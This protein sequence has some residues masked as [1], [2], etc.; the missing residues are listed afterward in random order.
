MPGSNDESAWCPKHFVGQA[1]HFV[2]A[3]NMPAYN[4]FYA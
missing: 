4:N 3:F 1:L 2:V